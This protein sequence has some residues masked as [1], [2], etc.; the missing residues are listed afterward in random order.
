MIFKVPTC[1]IVYLPLEEIIP[2]KLF[3][4]N[5]TYLIPW[6]NFKGMCQYIIVWVVLYCAH[7]LFGS[8]N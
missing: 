3:K 1:I 7:Q 2:G 5:V 4:K 8:V 6:N